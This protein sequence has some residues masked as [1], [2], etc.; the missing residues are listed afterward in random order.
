MLGNRQCMPFLHLANKASLQALRTR[1]KAKTSAWPVQTRSRT[2]TRAIGTRLG[3]ALQLESRAWNKVQKM[4]QS[5]R[6]CVLEEIAHLAPAKAFY[7][8]LHVR[9]HFDC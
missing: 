5:N 2:H 3:V 6:M 8:L 9:G 7:G 1:N 4:G